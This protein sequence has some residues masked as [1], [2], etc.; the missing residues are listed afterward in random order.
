MLT[1]IL[2]Q[3]TEQAMQLTSFS[4]N[5]VFSNDTMSSSAYIT[6]VNDASTINTLHA[7]GLAGITDLSIVGE[8][9]LIYVL[10]NQNAR[11]TTINESLDGEHI[12]VSF[13]IDFTI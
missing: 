12:N 10:S 5:T 9:G 6:V 1:L 3:Q 13:S 11:I 8:N 7:A 4:R 2:N